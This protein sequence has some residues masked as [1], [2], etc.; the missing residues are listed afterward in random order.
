[1]K[2]NKLSCFIIAIAAVVLSSC[3]KE[4]TVDVGPIPDNVC[5][6]FVT[7]VN[8][9]NS[10]STFEF[11][12]SGDSPLITLTSTASIKTSELAPGSR[13][14]IQYL[15]SGGQDV[16]QSGPITLYGIAQITNGNATTAPMADISAWGSDDIRVV[17][18]SRSGQYLD[19]WGEATM[20]GNPRRFALAAD[21]STLGDEYPMLY[22]IV[23]ADNVN[24]RVHQLYASF[25]MSAVWNLSTCKGVQVNFKT[26]AGEDFMVFDKG[27]R[28]PFQPA[29]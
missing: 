9:N 14:I 10:G 27:N 4:S 2:I 20:T 5:Y 8:S 7:F 26:S 12:K 23:D 13:V 24:G 22:L 1:M 28:Q 15:P 17:T 3:K 29:E 25:D 11:R 19:F 16:Y 6:D 18:L 21:E